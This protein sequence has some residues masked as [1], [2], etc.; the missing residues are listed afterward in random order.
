MGY[1]CPICGAEQVDGVHLANHL[2]V[3][4]SLD[5]RDHVEWLDE[6]APDW[7]ECGPAELA[8]RVVEYAP[9]VETP[10]FETESGSNPGVGFEDHI[11]AG[12][13]Q[14]GRGGPVER[15]DEVE[16]VLEEARELTEGLTDGPDDEPA[17]DPST[18]DENA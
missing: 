5:R 7:N 2:A 13:R 14:S 8:E 16:A 9:E 17:A 6:H 4:A 1:A 3:T 15:S 11:A 10:E 12:S 18:E